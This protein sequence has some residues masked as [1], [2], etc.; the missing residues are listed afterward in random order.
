MSAVA[1]VAASSSEDL[2]PL[3][4]A[5][6]DASALPW[7]A[8]ADASQPAADTGTGMDALN[9]ALVQLRDQLQDLLAAHTQAGEQCA[10]AASRL[11]A[12]FDD[13]IDGAADVGERLSS[14]G[15]QFAEDDLGDRGDELDGA[16]DDVEEA[17]NEQLGSAC[18][19]LTDDFEADCTAAYSAVGDDLE[20]RAGTLAQQIETRMDE[21]R[22]R[23]AAHFRGSVEAG[24]RD[25][26]RD[27]VA[28]MLDEIATNVVLTQASV[29]ITGAV[30]PILPQ[31][32]ALRAAVTAIKAA[33]KLMRGGF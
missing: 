27:A 5:L 3:I 28:G 32:V 13:R 23:S 24:A 12:E 31:L 1:Q 30:G 29:A 10:D 16:F 15:E 33:L 18:A 4:D 11:E 26:V 8:D 9:Q 6:R 7:L 21:L 20:Q 25:A 19:D 2:A 17:I 22:E 14:R